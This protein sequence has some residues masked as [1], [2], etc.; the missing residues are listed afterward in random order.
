MNLPLLSMLFS[1]AFTV[2]VGVLMIVAFVTGFDKMPHIIGAVV[3]GGLISL[4]VAVVLTKKISNLTS[5][6]S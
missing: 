2:I 5:S 4:P 3:I 1:M 6:K